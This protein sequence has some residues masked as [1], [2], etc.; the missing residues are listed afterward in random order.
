MAKV[1]IVISDDPS[2]GTIGMVSDPPAMQ[3]Y[4]KVQ[5]HGAEALTG[6]EGLAIS[7]FAH[8]LTHGAPNREANRIILPPGFKS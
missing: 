2:D 7:L 1:T 5:V 6:A 8:A 4:E 3:L